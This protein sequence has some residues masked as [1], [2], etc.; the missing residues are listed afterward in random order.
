M[1]KQKQGVSDKKT[2]AQQVSFAGLEF[3]EV[4]KDLLKIKPVENED[5][6]K[7]A[8]KKKRDTKSKGK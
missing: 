6:K 2:N 5:L 3:E 7:N 8:P 4:L 1:S